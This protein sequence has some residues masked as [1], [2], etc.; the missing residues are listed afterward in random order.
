MFKQQ[1]KL[2]LIIVDDHGAI[3]FNLL[4]FS[5]FLDNDKT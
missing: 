5:Y 1:F 2:L 4:F 3:F